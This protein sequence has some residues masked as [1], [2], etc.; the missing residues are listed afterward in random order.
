M[1]ILKMA[2]EIEIAN[3]EKEAK[4]YARLSK[5]Y[6]GIPQN[7]RDLVDGLIIEASRLR[8][9]LDELWLDIQKNGNTEI[10]ERGREKERPASAIF[11][12]RDK[13]YRMTIKHLDELLP[14]KKSTGGAF[15][16]LDDDEDEDGNEG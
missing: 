10:D 16:K 11:T 14:T 4:E 12:A 8:V 15:S 2:N 5:L 7:K 1:E 13:S 9:S 3:L 6:E